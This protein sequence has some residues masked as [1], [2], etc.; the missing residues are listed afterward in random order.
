MVPTDAIIVDQIE[1]LF[2]PA[3][4]GWRAFLAPFAR[5]IHPALEGVSFRV[6]DG[7][8]LALVGANGAG[9]STL[10]R[11]LTTLLLPTR[12]IANVAGWDVVRDAA[13][14]RRALGFHSGAEAGFYARLTALQNLKFF[15]SLRDLDPHL[16]GA[17]G[18]RGLAVPA[19]TAGR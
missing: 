8:S 2:P 18:L 4:S 5:P 16:R 6:R 17:A 11:V 9:K 19:E 1:K 13:R 15:A 10:L 12:G 7:E 14:V 3:Q